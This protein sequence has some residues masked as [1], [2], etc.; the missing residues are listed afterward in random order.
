MNDAPA[1]SKANHREDIKVGGGLR[2]ALLVGLD[3]IH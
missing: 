3:N 1:L 2:S